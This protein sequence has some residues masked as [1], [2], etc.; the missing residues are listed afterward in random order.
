MDQ[1]PLSKLPRELRD[2]IYDASLKLEHPIRVTVNDQ[3]Q[4]DF[5]VNEDTLGIMN[6]CKQM[7]SEA[8]ECLLANHTIIV[9]EQTPSKVKSVVRSLFDSIGDRAMAA[10]R[11]LSIRMMKRNRLT[12]RSSFWQ[13]SSFQI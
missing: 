7:E 8:L 6:T 10:M 3:R 1:S 13:K 12:H 2:L 9:Q 4:I 11:S 5:R